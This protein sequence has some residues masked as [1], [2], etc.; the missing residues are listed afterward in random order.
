MMR[1]SRSP[2][3]LVIF[4]LASSTLFAQD[5]RYLNLHHVTHISG[6]WVAFD[7]GRLYACRFD[8]L[9]GSEEPG[10]SE[11]SGL[12]SNMQRVTALWGEGDTAWVAYTDGHVYGCRRPEQANTGKPHCKVASGL[13]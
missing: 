2:A 4:L 6:G 12:P 10:C 8:H 7:N 5:K 13:P 3:L 1:F 9:P 11:A